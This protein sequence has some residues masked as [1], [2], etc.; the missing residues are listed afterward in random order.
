[1]TIS[2]LL[3]T[4]EDFGGAD[5]FGQS[6]DDNRTD[7]ELAIFERGYKAGWEDSATA[8]E[9]SGTALSEHFTQNL[10][11]LS[12]TYHEAYTAVLRS[13]EPLVRQLVES[14]VPDLA[15]EG[16]GQTLAAEVTKIAQTHA[17]SQILISC[18]SSKRAIL[19][20]ALPK[21]PGLDLSLLAD[22][23]LTPDQVILRFAGVE[24]EIDVTRFAAQAR[25]LI[26]SFFEELK[27]E[28]KNG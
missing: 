27:K 21:N 6:S 20:A 17:G 26:H 14:T 4:F 13:L 11:D 23:G 8:A 24:R 18:H 2:H 12:F 19:Q 5:A 15:S 25:D 9:K 1:M 3:E 22:S 7:H 10:S 16:L 28:P